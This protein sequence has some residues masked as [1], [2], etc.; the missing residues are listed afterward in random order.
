MSLGFSMAH[1][2]E[3]SPKEEAPGLMLNIETAGIYY[4]KPEGNSYAKFGMGIGGEYMIFNR[5]PSMF[6]LSP[7]VNYLGANEVRRTYQVEHGNYYYRTTHLTGKISLGINLIYKYQVRYKW[8]I[9]VGFQ[10]Q[11][12]LAT[13]KSQ[14]IYGSTTAP[15]PDIQFNKTE[16]S[17]LG[18]A[19]YRIDRKHQLNVLC[20][21]GLSK[22][23]Q[24]ANE[25][26][27]IALR[28]QI[29]RSL[30]TL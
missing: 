9:G 22:S 30:F 12:V 15:L 14:T 18:F 23:I 3:V 7:M 16:S 2:Q 29:S 11:F 20:Q 21:Y 25:P 5:N 26:G 4:T 27:S 24:G 1:A 8:R 13:F 28:F 17:L 6:S 10:P 19:G